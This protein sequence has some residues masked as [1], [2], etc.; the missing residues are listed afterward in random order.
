M[1]ERGRIETADNGLYTVASLDRDGI[2]SLPISPADDAVYQV[3]D[4]VYFVIFKD[5]T[6]KILFA[7]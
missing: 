2:V 5:G 6:G 7:L 4:L 3:G 1:I